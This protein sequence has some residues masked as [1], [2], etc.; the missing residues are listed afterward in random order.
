MSFE[1]IED[2][3]GQLRAEIAGGRGDLH[4]EEAALA[5]VIVLRQHDCG[6]TPL[7]SQEP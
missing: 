1:R 3:R 7:V 6:W 5:I 4:V 2:P